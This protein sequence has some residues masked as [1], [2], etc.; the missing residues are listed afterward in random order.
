MADA[1]TDL[2]TS[3]TLARRRADGGRAVDYA[4]VERELGA[5]TIR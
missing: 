2:V 1:V 3:V 5:P 4:Q